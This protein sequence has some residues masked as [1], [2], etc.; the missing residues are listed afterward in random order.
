M[1]DGSHF[2]MAFLGVVRPK[3]AI[4]GGQ[5]M[6]EHTP[7]NTTR[8]P[9]GPA[10]FM[11]A[12]FVYL[13]VVHGLSLLSIPSPAAS[14]PFDGVKA[15]P[16]GVEAS[17]NV[18]FGI[19]GHSPRLIQGLAVLTLYGCMITLFNLTRRLVKGPVWLGS[20]AAA[21]FMAHPVKTEVM[22]SAYGLFEL[23]GA[24]LALL[25]LLAYL[26][27]I[28]SPSGARILVALA[29][30]TMA[31]LPFSVNA[32]LFGVLIMLE[33]FPGTPETRHW[34]RL[35]PFLVVALLAN[36]IHR[37]TLYTGMPDF[38]ANIA[39]LLLLIYPIGLLPDTLAQLQAAP[40]L[41]WAWALLVLLLL[42]GS[43]VWVGNGG[44]RVA[45]LALLSYRFYPGADI[46]DL[47]SLEGGGQLLVPLA[48]ACVAMAGFCRWL[49]H[50]EVWG[51]PAI[52]LTTMLCI[53]LFTLQFQ[54]N[55]AYMNPANGE[56]SGPDAV[57]ELEGGR[58]V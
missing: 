23:V 12:L 55:R 38:R 57:R 49:L 28:E 5:I 40:L 17:L 30:F 13:C 24:L 48:L 3:P 54:A 43:M 11:A 32:T 35:V 53:V 36:S 6:D 22:F 15:I 25:T 52:A 7:S 33:F 29:C 20:L 21:V 8:K 34:G 51:K 39:P 4:I 1:V 18:F 42:L 58:G 27:L 19:L 37:E 56:T 10:F 41:A 45:L 16:D 14:T 26:R 50:F 9:P 31:T 46:I 47:V 2:D 44:Y